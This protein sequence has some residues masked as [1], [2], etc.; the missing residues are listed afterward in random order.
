M[1]F[2]EQGLA[3]GFERTCGA[4]ADALA[5]EDA[6]GVGH[7]LVL[8]GGDGGVEATAVEIQRKRKLGIIGTD[9]DTPPAVNALAV[10]ALVKRV[11][12]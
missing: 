1:A 10:I 9:L 8:E 12:I 11:V 2:F 3:F 5:A 6:G 4:H 7:G